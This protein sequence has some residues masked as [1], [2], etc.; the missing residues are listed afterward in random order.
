MFEACFPPV[1]V[2]EIEEEIAP[3]NL[4]LEAGNKARRTEENLSERYKPFHVISMYREMHGQD[5]SNIF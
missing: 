4:L 3:L 2:S 5:L 1:P